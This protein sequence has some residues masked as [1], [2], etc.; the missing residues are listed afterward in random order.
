MDTFEAWTTVAIGFAVIG[1]LIMTQMPKEWQTPGGYVLVT[2][3]GIPA[4][5]LV[6]ATLA[7]P[8]IL[9]PAVFAFGVLC[10]T[11]RRP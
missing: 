9:I 10:A 5:L 11:R 6:I 4:A 8:A 3:G 2:F 1:L 7:Q